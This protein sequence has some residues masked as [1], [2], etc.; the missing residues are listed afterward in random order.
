MKKLNRIALPVIMAGMLAIAAPLGAGAFNLGGA[1][2]QRSVWL[3]VD[4]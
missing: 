1:C 4:T 3:Q 2:G